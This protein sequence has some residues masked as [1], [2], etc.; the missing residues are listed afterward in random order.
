[1]TQNQIAYQNYLESR[2]SNQARE[3]ETART[4]RANEDIRRDTNAVSREKIS[5]DQKIAEA[6]RLSSQLI[7]KMN[8]ES[9]ERIAR[10]GNSTTA[11]IAE[12][13]R[14][15]R[16]DIAEANRLADQFGGW[17]ILINEIK[18]LLFPDSDETS[19]GSKVGKFAKGVADTFEAGLKKL[20]GGKKDVKKGKTRISNEQIKLEG[21]NE[22]RSKLPSSKGGGSR[23]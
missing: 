15:S 12:L 19:G 22:T 18:E 16:E 9:R 5:S 23:H 2:R 13:D 3:S 20:T 1:M 8:N 10:E 4:N 7:A 14:L 21:P 6:N 11:L 17:G